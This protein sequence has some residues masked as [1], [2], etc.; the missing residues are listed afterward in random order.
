MR[1]APVLL[2]VLGIHAAFGEEPVVV[3]AAA[4]L[5]PVLPKLVERFTEETGV[6][7]RVV[8]GSSGKLA[9][10][11]L[12]G[13]PF[14]VL[15]SADQDYPAKVAVAGF[16]S[17]DPRTYAV[18]ILVACFRGGTE[19]PIAIANPRTAPYG[20]AAIQYLTKVWGMDET[21]ANLVIGESVGQAAQFF[22]SGNVNRAFLA[23]SQVI[24]FEFYDDPAYRFLDLTGPQFDPIRQDLLLLRRDGSEPRKAAAAFAD[25]LLSE[26]GREIL[27]ASGYRLP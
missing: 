4:N 17:G 20:R 8:Y 11:I 3:A 14:E 5:K 7:T 19:S 2:L 24:E 1:L 6:E 22:V 27:E 9:S 23:K 13:A 26:S 15:L 12:N 21:R 25:F 16:G 18:G 10:Q